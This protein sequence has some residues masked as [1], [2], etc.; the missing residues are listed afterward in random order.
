VWVY[1]YTG[2]R[3]RRREETSPPSMDSQDVG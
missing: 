3:A 1:W 2:R